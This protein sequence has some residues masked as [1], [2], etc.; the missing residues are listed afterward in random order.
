MK[1]NK[2]EFNPLIFQALKDNILE[3]DKKKIPSVLKRVKDYI[4]KR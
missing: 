1:E 2:E 3:Q 4:I